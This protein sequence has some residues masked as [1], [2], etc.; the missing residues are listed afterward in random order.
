MIVYLAGPINGCSDAEAKDWRT[1]ARE[2]LFDNGVDVL[3]PMVRDYR[4]NE[5]GNE[6]RIVEG[7]KADILTADVVLVMF[8]RPSVGTSMEVLFAWQN[9]RPVVVVAA[10]A[11]RLSPWLVYHSFSVHSNLRK[12]CEFIVSQWAKPGLDVE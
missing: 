10:G 8:A 5:A 1:T 9:S 4:G 6:A 11:G 3:D 7:D 12:A 2:L